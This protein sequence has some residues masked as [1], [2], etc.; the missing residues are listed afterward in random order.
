MCL[1]KIILS[2]SPIQFPSDTPVVS[3]RVLYDAQHTHNN[4]R[5]AG[6]PWCTGT[7]Y[8]YVD[9]AYN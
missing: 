3:S 6:S 9:R 5:D 8:R 7:Q 4:A 1:S 2:T